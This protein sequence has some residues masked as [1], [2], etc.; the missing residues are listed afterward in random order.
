MT[1][2]R[3]QIVDEQTPGFYHC[4]NRCVRRTF[5]CGLD[6]VTGF[7][8]SHRKAWIEKRLLELSEI[9][10][11][12]IFAYAVMDNHYHIVLQV[13]P[14]APLKWSDEDV[15]DK[16]LQAYGHTSPRIKNDLRATLKRQAIMADKEKLKTYRKRLGS[17][18]WFM[19]R[20][21]E[22]LAKQSNNEENCTGR[23]WEGRFHSQALLDEGAVLSCMTY[24]DLNP[25][26]AN[27]AQTLESSKHTSIKQ[28]IKEVKKKGSILL[29]K[30]LTS[31]IQSFS[32][33]DKQKT[34]SIKLKE[35]IQLVEWTGHSILYSGKSN[36]PMNLQSTFDRFNLQQNNWLSQ[37]KDFNENYCHVIGPIDLI[38]NKA[39]QIKKR[40]LKGVTAARLLYQNK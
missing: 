27:I 30:Q 25:I 28:R 40:C 20:L 8:Y 21:N 23:F 31:D 7:D 33:K 16:W 5:L 1:I 18:S 13:D 37:I 22:P 32:K 39:L 4:T 24:V 14:L 10:S 36:L 19:G 12:E 29:Q 15:A 34:L 26:R 17:L 11:V 9:F 38:R 6:E 35:Y 2:A 3:K